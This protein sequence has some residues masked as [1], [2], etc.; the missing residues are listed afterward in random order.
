MITIFRGDSMTSRFGRS[1]TF[2][3]ETDL[4]TSG[5]S[6]VFS[7]NGIDAVA[8]LLDGR[9]TVTLTAEQTAQLNYGTGYASISFV[10][11]QDVRTV[12]NS[13]PVRVTDSV[14]EMDG[15]TNTISVT[16]APD[17][18]EALK[19]VNWDAGGSIGALRDFLARIGSA[20]GATV[21]A[22]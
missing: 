1:L 5:V 15:A 19:G 18:S 2:E 14:E 3:V 11:G 21:T 12:T 20:L 6:V 9:A 10:A 4:D 8:S 7:L 17:W 16:L 13:I 22:R